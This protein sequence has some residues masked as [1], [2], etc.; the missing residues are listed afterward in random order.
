VRFEAQ[1]GG[2]GFP[3]LGYRVW[4][5]GGWSEQAATLPQPGIGVQ[6]FGIEWA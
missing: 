5:T 4:R 6:N 2:V 1:A 3:L